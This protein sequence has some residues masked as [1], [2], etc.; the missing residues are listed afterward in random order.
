M[1]RTADPRNELKRLLA[2]QSETEARI[3]NAEDRL[4]RKLGKIVCDT[5]AQEFSD[6]SLR[7]LL[8]LAVELGE[9]Q[10][11]MRLRGNGNQNQAKEK[12]SEDRT[13]VK[14]ASQ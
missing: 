6:G 10:S 14:S 9:A 7:E 3:K 12:P 4:Q 11:M 8:S 1:P 2:E 13:A 5:G